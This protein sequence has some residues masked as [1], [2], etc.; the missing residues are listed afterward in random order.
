MT[1]QPIT[2][3]FQQPTATWGKYNQS[4]F[5]IAQYLVTK[6][7][8]V[9]LVRVESCTNSGGVSQ[10]GFVNITPLINQ[11]DPNGN[12]IPH[13]TI[14]NVPYFRAQGGA[15]AIIM[16]PQK[17]DIGL[18]CFASRD[19]S[20]V[21]K[22][23]AQANPGSLRSFSWSDALYFGG[24]LNA[25]PTNYVQFEGANIN[26]TSTGQ[27]NVSAPAINLGNG[28]T[29]TQLVNDT[30]LALFNAHTHPVSGILAG[31]TTTPMT[32]TQLTSI[33]KAQ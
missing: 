2:S 6:L 12:P 3:G 23:R 29:L 19:I 5:E 10:V 22:S 15:N 17:G 30:L 21:K 11:I 28:G 31:P 20:N 27:V 7:Q 13:V 32:S 25:P 26:I 1:D 8:T 4:Q 18:A 24:L 33:V 14:Y 16:D 9:T